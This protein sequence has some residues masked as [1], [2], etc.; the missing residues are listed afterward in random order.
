ML[1]E[2]AKIVQMSEVKMHQNVH[3]C[4]YRVCTRNVARDIGK[5]EINNYNCNN[6]VAREKGG[7]ANSYISDA[8]GIV[9]LP[10]KEQCARR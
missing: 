6:K 9:V 3:K 4:A 7:V 2:E 10:M 5:S 1:V 8:I